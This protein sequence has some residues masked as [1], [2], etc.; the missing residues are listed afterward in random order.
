[1]EAG[2]AN[3]GEL[4]LAKVDIG[5]EQSW[6]KSGSQPLAKTV[7]R[8][9]HGLRRAETAPRPAQVTMQAGTRDA[10]AEFMIPGEL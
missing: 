3:V 4:V 5:V 10:A 1:M 6:T 7:A 2:R 8:G 9:G